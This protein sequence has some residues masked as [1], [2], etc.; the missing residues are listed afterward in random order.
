MGER[1][2]RLAWSRG[3][4]YTRLVNA[5]NV[6]FRL[7]LALIC[8]VM[9]LWLFVTSFYFMRGMISNPAYHRAVMALF[10]ALLIS[11]LFA[12]CTYSLAQSAYIL[13]TREKPEAPASTISTTSLVVGVTLLLVFGTFV[14]R[15]FI[16]F[17]PG[18]SIFRAPMGRQT[19]GNLGALRSAMSI[20]YGDM[21][22]QYPATMTVLT[23]GGRWMGKLERADTG[24][25]PPNAA[26]QLMTAEEIAAKSFRDDGGWYYVTSGSNT[27]NIGVN[28]VHTDVKGSVWIGY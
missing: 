1:Q 19:L 25:H 28:C 6:V 24:M 16:M 23:I 20:Y 11:A 2:E 9:S 27:G 22:G 21:E 3:E 17:V 26:I 15:K 8:G 10:V 14:Y 13:A 12:K 5:L 18:Q 7:L 4:A